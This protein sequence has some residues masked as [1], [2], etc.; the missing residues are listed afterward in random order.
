MKLKISESVNIEVKVAQSCPILSTPWT[1]QSTEF[2]R[3]DYWSGQPIPSLEDLPD[4]GT[5]LGSPAL[6]ADYLPTELSGNWLTELLKN[7]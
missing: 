4:P 2:S 6:Q 7:L 3:P 5:K 1:I